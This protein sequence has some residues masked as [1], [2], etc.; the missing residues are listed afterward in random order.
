[1]KKKEKIVRA[2]TAAEI[3]GKYLYEF[4]SILNDALTFEN[5]IY[6]RYLLGVI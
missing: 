1:M 6:L 3:M 5:L 4:I 2:F